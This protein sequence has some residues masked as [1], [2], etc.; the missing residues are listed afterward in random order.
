LAST[1]SSHTRFLHEPVGQSPPEPHSHV[2][3]VHIPVRHSAFDA[4]AGGG[5][6]TDTLPGW[7]SA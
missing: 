6:Q 2:P 3:A 5:Y 1:A 7:L 4:Q